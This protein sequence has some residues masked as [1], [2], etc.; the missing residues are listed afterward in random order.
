MFVL[1]FSATW[2]KL[3]YMHEGSIGY[4]SLQRSLFSTGYIHNFVEENESF[5][6]FKFHKYAKPDLC[7]RDYRSYRKI[8]KIIL[9]IYLYNHVYHFILVFSI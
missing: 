8:I 2:Q 4:S 6:T 7:D 5:S 3:R 9:E 1:I